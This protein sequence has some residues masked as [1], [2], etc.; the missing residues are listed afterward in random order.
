[1]VETVSLEEAIAKAQLPALPGTAVQL[2]E[3]SQDP[4]VPP[5][6]YARIIEADVGLLGQ[7]LKFV[8]STYFGFSRKISSVE[9][10]ISLVGIRSIKNFAVWNAV[11]SLIPSPKVGSFDLKQLWMDSLRRAVFARTL[12]RELGIPNS[13]ELFSAALLQDMAIPVLLTG[14]PE[15][16]EDLIQ[17][18]AAENVRLSTLE[19][20]QFGWDHAEAAAL[21]CR[22]WRL[23]PDFP[24]LIEQHPS[25]NMLIQAGPAKV[26]C[27][28]VALA[29]MLPSCR[30]SVWNEQHEFFNGLASL[31][32]NRQIHFAKFFSVIEREFAEFA[33]ILGLPLPKKSLA[34]LFKEAAMALRTVGA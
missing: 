29:S 27:A 4:N 23:P 16:Y 20:N 8:N 6:K 7:I 10:A 30:D 9:Q 5:S 2:L 11:F 26:D 24:R 19:R 25:L 15:V 12:G 1:M 14:I 13:E 32:T 3:L 21:L 18:R 22:S 31:T 28:C 33:P 17:R 34:E